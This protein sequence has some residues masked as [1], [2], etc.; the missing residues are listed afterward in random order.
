MRVLECLCVFDPALRKKRVAGADTGLSSSFQCLVF[1]YG[2]ARV[3]TAN[4]YIT[5]CVIR[6]DWGVYRLM[7]Q[8]VPGQVLFRTIK[9]VPLQTLPPKSQRAT[10]ADGTSVVEIPQRL[11]TSVAFHRSR[12]AWTRLTGRDSEPRS[13]LL[14]RRYLLSTYR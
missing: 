14:H 8:C 3:Y 13:P 11:P 6:H 12:S 1:A 2:C 5:S 10:Q 4:L 7:N 9:F